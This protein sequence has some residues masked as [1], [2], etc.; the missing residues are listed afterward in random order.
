MVGV[1]AAVLGRIGE[2]KEMQEG[3]RGSC[4]LPVPR[5]AGLLDTLLSLWDLV[6][7]ATSPNWNGFEKCTRSGPISEPAVASM[8]PQTGQLRCLEGQTGVKP[9]S[10][11]D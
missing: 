4:K 3:K 10:K 8:R 6:V 5:A 2:G 11:R 7:V 9:G 1:Q